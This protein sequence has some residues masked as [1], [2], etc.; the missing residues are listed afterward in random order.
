ML[1]DRSVGAAL[2]SVPAPTA[3][4][5]IAPGHI[6]VV[7]IEDAGSVVHGASKKPGERQN[8]VMEGFVP[9]APAVPLHAAGTFT[10]HE[11]RPCAADSRGLY[12]LMGIHADMSLRR[13]FDHFLEMLDAELAVT[14]FPSVET[15]PGIAGFQIMNAMRRVP[16]EIPFELRLIACHIPSGLVV[17]DEFYPFAAGIGGHLFDVKV[18]GGR[19]EIEVTRGSVP[20]PAVVP[21]LE[22]HTLDIIGG[23]EVDVADGGLGGRSVV[24]ADA[25][26]FQTQMQA[27][28]Y[29]YVFGGLDPGD[30][31]QGA[32]F[33]QVKYQRGI[34]QAY[35]LTG[36]L[37]GAPGRLEA[38]GQDGL[39]TAPAVERRE[40]RHKV[41][42]IGASQDH[43]GII[44]D[45]CFVHAGIEAAVEAHGHGSVG[46]RD[47]A[48]AELAVFK[49]IGV[50]IAGNGPAVGILRKTEFG[51]FSVQKDGVAGRDFIFIP[52][53]E[54]IVEHAEAERKFHPFSIFQKCRHLIV[55]VAHRLVLPPWLGPFFVCR[56][57]LN[58]LESEAGGKIQPIGVKAEGG[59]SDEWRPVHIHGI[60]RPALF[61]QRKAK[62]DMAVGRANGCVR[63]AG[64][65]KEDEREKQSFHGA[66]ISRSLSHMN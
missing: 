29:T 47:I 55:A 14:V 7:D 49:F 22:K 4:I 44:V 58:L 60:Y 31:F 42:V 21:S 61:R 18:G 43:L 1:A 28:P 5:G 13:L 64:G 12:G 41:A 24:R 3:Q 2:G 19:C 35:R 57:L 52:P 11:I 53:C 63:P 65:K 26:G 51:F 62:G 46:V 9:F 56:R 6:A 23:G 32:G 27:P 40:F 45:G 38:T 66:A 50:E 20:Y 59:F 48:Q 16:V 8:L 30:I 39:E 37:H 17:D 25:P 36:Y 33:V 34:Y 15:S 10:R 54:A